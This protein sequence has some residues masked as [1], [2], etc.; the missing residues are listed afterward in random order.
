VFAEVSVGFERIEALEAALPPELRREPLPWD[1][2]F[3]SGKVFVD[4]RRRG[5]SRLA[6]LSDFFIGAYAAV[7]GYR[8]LTRDT[9]RYQSCFLTVRLVA[10]EGC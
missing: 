9:R 5:G 2:A 4:Y 10:P 3:P 8:R 1:A 7:R 6:P